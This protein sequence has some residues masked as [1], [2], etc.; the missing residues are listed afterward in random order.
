[1]RRIVAITVV[2]VALSSGASSQTKDKQMAERPAASSQESQVEQEIMKVV[3]EW[4]GALKRRDREALIRIESEDFLYTVGEK[5]RFGNRDD[6]IADLGELKVD[7]IGSEVVATRVYGDVALVA[8]RG[9]IKSTFK[10]KDFSGNFLESTVWVKRDGRWQVVA[11]HLS[12]I[13]KQ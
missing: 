9:R 5:D 10:N 8:F 4:Q 7:S 11:A 6:A 2:A 1:M 3:R 13:A 12:R